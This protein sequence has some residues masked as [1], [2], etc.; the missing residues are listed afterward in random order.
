M[1][2]GLVLGRALVVILAILATGCLGATPGPEKTPVRPAAFLWDRPYP[3]LAV[4]IDVA[5]GIEPSEFAVD[6]LMTTL[7]EV[8]GK[9]SITR[10]PLSKLP[11][12]M[13]PRTD[14][15][16]SVEDLRQVAKA[17][18]STGDF[19]AYGSGST[20][21][22]HILYLYGQDEENG[23]VKGL[24]MDGTVIIF[25]PYKL[26]GAPE[27]PVEPRPTTRDFFERSILIHEMGHVLG[28]VDNGLPMQRDHSHP[29][30]PIHSSNKESVM[31]AGVDLFYAQ[32]GTLFPDEA[33]PYE[34]DA[35][36]LAD[37]RAFQMLGPKA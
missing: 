26:V 15:K 12:D 36:D 29:D 22:L 10:L 4:E 3:N 28:L 19:G 25:M 1:L 6:A 23:N 7:G 5:E 33:P 20:A 13:A 31:W 30:D 21:V 35:D 32:V 34:F 11:E 17:S 8:T 27:T 14:K 18:L 16:W 24:A 37:I 2:Q 9:Q